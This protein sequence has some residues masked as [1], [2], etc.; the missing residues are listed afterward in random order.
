MSPAAAAANQS[1]LKVSTSP[2]PG[3]RMAVEIGVPAGL[4]QSS[5]E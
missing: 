3:S 2:R 4:T 5:H 1:E